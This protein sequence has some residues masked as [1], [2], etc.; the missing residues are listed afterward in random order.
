[1]ASL[2]GGISRCGLCRFYAHEGRRG[3]LCSQLNAPVDSKWTACR[4]GVSPFEKAESWKNAHS[5]AVI[6]PVGRD[7]LRSSGKA[8]TAPCGEVTALGQPGILPKVG[9]SFV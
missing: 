8:K 1:M 9:L 3:G 5:S 7:A 6:A 4:L 2:K